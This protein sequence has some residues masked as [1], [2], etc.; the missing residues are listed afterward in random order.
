MAQARGEDVPPGLL[1]YP[2]EEARGLKFFTRA[3]AT[4]ARY[5]QITDQV[6]VTPRGRLIG[7]VEEYVELDMAGTDGTGVQW[8]AVLAVHPTPGVEGRWTI[9]HT[10]GMQDRVPP[11]AD[12]ITREVIELDPWSY[13]K[14]EG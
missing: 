6:A 8:A 5:V 9:T 1:P 7:T 2:G 3:R 13:V 10:R 11:R 4:P 12:V 14:K